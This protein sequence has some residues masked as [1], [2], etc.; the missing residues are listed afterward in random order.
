MALF[1][2][3]SIALKGPTNRLTNLVAGSIF[4]LGAFIT[5]VDAV[6][7]NLYG[8]YNLSLG[9]AVVALAL[10]ILLAYRMPKTRP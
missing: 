8:L 2:T 5:F 7:V 9:L 10:V 1:G 4:G 6:T 3:L